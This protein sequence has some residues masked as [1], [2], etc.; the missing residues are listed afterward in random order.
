MIG[1]QLMN[2]SEGA[3]FWERWSLM[4]GEIRLPV[5]SS[6]QCMRNLLTELNVPVLLR[7]LNGGCVLQVVHNS[8][9]Y[10]V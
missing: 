7:T 5:A 2:A 9:L 6:I 3:A 1:Y 10:T 8:N 4:R